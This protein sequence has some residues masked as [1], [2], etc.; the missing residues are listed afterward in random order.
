MANRDLTADCAVCFSGG[1]DSMLALDRAVRG[2]RRIRRLVTLY[3]AATERVR[4]HAVPIAVMQ[5]QA[6]ALGIPMRCY[7]TAP[8]TFE[9]V[10]LK[11]LAELRADGIG[12]LIFGDIHLADVR[13]WYEERVR[14]AEL[15]HVEPLWGEEPEALARESVARGYRALITCI[16][17]ARTDPAWL[18][19][20]LSDELIDA[21]IARGIDP[22]GEHGEYHTLVVDGPLFQYPVPISSGDRRSSETGFT[23]LDVTLGTDE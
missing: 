3:D 2:G 23:Q 5:T 11:A 20:Y 22:C 17:D 18:G 16:E 7:L 15:E 6:E 19:E 9:A 21:C 12:T 8:A 4:F 10:F 14:A 13:A 1:K